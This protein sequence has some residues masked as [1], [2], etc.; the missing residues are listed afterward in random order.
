[1]TSSS[2]DVDLT[3]CTEVIIRGSSTGT[4][5]SNLNAIIG[6]KSN[7]IVAP[8]TNNGTRYVHVWLKD[9]GLGNIVPI[10]ARYGTS[11]TNTTN[12][13]GSMPIVYNGT[14]AD[15]TSFTQSATA[16][17]TSC[18]LNIYAR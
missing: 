1:M 9:D 17:V 15:I 8:I 4:A 18:A 7:Q 13:F 6:G 12:A 2:I 16:N 10:S 14:I 3:G 11:A 5:N